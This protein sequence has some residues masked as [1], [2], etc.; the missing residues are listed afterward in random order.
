V[1]VV[2]LADEL[3]LLEAEDFVVVEVVVLDTTEAI[4]VV[5]GVDD[6]EEVEVVEVVEVVLGLVA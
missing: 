3:V 4:D 6:V 2:I 1:S 5:A